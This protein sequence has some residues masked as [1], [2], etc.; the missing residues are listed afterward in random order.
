MLTGQL[1]DIGGTI[2]EAAIV[3]RHLLFVCPCGGCG[4]EKLRTPGVIAH[5]EDYRAIPLP[6]LLE[7]VPDM[8]QKSVCERKVVE[9]GGAMVGKRTRGSTVDAVGMRNGQVQEDEGV[10]TILQQAVGGAQE[11]LIVGEVER[12]GR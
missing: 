2:V 6:I 12:V 10:G 11:H 5:D 8:G 1:D 3:A 9:I 7:Q 4:P